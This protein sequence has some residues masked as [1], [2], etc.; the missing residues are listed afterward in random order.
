MTTFWII[1]RLIAALCIAATI[2][3]HTEPNR[4]VLFCMAVWVIEAGIQTAFSEEKQ[5]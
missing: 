4:F 2:L 5:Q 1:A 3:G